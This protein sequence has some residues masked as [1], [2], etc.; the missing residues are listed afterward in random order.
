MVY[1]ARILSVVVSNTGFTFKWCDAPKELDVVK[2]LSR[3]DFV[4]LHNTT[5]SRKNP[6]TDLLHWYTATFVINA[7]SSIIGELHVCNP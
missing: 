7:Y 3:I 5:F 4:A 1:A 2:K 6:R